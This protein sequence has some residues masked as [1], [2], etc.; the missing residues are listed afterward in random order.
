MRMKSH[1]SPF[2]NAIETVE[3]LSPEDQYALMQLIQRRLVEWRRTEI[4]HHATTT[5]QA[6][7]SGR[8]SSGSLDDLKHDLLSEFE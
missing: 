8:A 4:A 5:L 7:R 2:Q 1:I 3:A 6:V